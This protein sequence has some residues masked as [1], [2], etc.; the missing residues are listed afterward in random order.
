M[1]ISKQRSTCRSESR[2]GVIIQDSLRQNA[3]V[4]HC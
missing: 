2:Q 4:A 1:T 3:F